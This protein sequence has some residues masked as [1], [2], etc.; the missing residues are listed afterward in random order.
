MDENKDILEKAADVLKNEKIPPGPSQELVNQTMARLA[1][2]SEHSE[3]IQLGNRIRLRERLRVINHFYKVAAAI[4]LLLVGGYAIG[5]FSAPRPPDMEEL[6]AALVPAIREELIDE[7]NE[8]LQS[9][10]A[11]L[12]ESLDQKYQQDLNRVGMQILAASNTVTNERLAGLIESFNE[13]QA[14][15]RQ[16]FT[17]MLER[18]ESNRLQ[19][20]AVLSNALVTVAQQTKEE[21]ERTKQDIVQLLPY[22]QPTGSAPD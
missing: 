11:S 5:R 3:T 14:Q 8:N 16:W 19:D 13:Y 22:T 17:T 9:S 21:M 15:E 20:S 6:Q 12:T 7:I 10:Y 4:I 18:M 2:A 1:E